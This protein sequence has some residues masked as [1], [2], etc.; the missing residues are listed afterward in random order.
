MSEHGLIYLYHLAR[1]FE[2][3]R[4]VKEDG[5][6]HFSK[7]SVGITQALRGLMN[8]ILLNYL[9]TSLS[10]LLCTIT[11]HLHLWQGTGAPSRS[12]FFRGIL[13]KLFSWMV[14]VVL[15]CRHLHTN[16]P[17]TSPLIPAAL[18]L[19]SIKSMS[20]NQLTTPSLVAKRLNLQWDQKLLALIPHYFFI[21]GYYKL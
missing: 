2:C 13:E 1:T 16:P 9:Y 4:H 18:L 20:R 21:Y 3:D 8:Y 14:L 7:P 19:Q 5:G 6:A 10:V 17:F 12:Q 15:H 11:S